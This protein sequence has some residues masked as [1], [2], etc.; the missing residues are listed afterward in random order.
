MP[1]SC[2][3]RRTRRGICAT[4]AGSCFSLRATIRRSPAWS[5]S[6][7]AFTASNAA[8][9]AQHVLDTFF[10]KQEGRPLPPQA[11]RS[12]RTLRSRTTSP[13][14]TDVFERRLYHHIDWALLIAIL[15]LCALGVAMI[16]STTSDPTRG[17]FASLHHAAVRH[18]TRARSRWCS[19]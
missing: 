4:T 8:P 2:G 18:R 13:G 11:R 14:R 12:F 16:Y 3:G 9:I 10:A 1:A 17:Q 5:S 15:A 7:T 6:N 19:R